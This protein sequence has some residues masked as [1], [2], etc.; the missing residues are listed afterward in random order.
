MLASINDSIVRRE[1]LTK[2]GL[3]SLAWKVGL[4]DIEKRSS[5]VLVRR[6]VMFTL[7]NEDYANFFVNVQVMSYSLPAAGVLALELL[8]QSRRKWSNHPHTI[9][10]TQTIQDLSV[11]LVHM[12]VLVGPGDGKLFLSPAPLCHA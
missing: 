7:I 9:S 1:R 6:R 8:Q 10:R 3:S 12:D 4:T 2:L 5:G 11:L